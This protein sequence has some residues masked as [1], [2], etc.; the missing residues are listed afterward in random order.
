MLAYATFQAQGYPIGSGSVESANKVVVQSRLKGAG[1]RWA[2]EHV[3][4]MLAMSNLACNDHW[5]EGWSAIRKRWQQE[6]RTKRHLRASSPSRQNEGEPAPP[7]AP[8]PPTPP[9]PRGRRQPTGVTPR[10]PQ[11]QPA[12]V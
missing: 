9:S 5:D 6:A 10:K 12:P 3:N 4:A 1:M 11:V 7:A 2:D 8:T